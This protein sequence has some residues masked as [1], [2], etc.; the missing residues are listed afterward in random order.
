MRPDR[1]P[2]K[3]FEVSDRADLVLPK[4]T[5]RPM[6]TSN[7]L[8]LALSSKKPVFD[9]F[10]GLLGLRRGNPGPTLAEPETVVLTTPLVREVDGGGLL[11]LVRLTVRGLPVVVAV[12]G[13]RDRLVDL[14][15]RLV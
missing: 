3:A 10:E 9:A 15:R 5:S 8:K 2:L 12:G 14:E 13:G 6:L 11:E 1:F 7:D 4:V